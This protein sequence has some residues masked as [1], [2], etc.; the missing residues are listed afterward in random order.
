LGI[1]LGIGA[2]VIGGAIAASQA[3]AAQRQDAVD[4]C[5]QRFRSFD[6]ASMTYLGTDGLRHPCP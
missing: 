2:A 3:Q 4:Y 5:L 6:P 1:G